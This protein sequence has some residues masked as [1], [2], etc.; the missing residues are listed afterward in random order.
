MIYNGSDIKMVHFEPT[1]KCQ[2]SCPMC[3]RNKNGGEVNQYLTNRDISIE[4]FKKIFSIDFL[5]QL[6][7]FFFC[8]NHG[9]P[10]LCPDLIPMVKYVREHNP[11]IRMWITT[12][13]GARTAK[14]W[15]E[16]AQYIS[17]VNF[18]VD[19]LEDTNHLYRQGVVWDKVD[20]AM[21]AFCGA[22]GKAE[23]TFL[24]FEYNEHQVEHARAYAEMLGVHK[25]IVKKSGRYITTADLE[26]K[27]THT[28][29]DKKGNRNILGKPK[30]PKYH[31]KATEVDY[32]RIVKEYGSLNNYIESAQI[33]PKC[34]QKKEIY[35]SA[36]GLVFQCCWLGGQIYKWWRPK[37][38]GDIYQLIEKTGGIDKIN[39]LHYPIEEILQS[40]FYNKVEESWNLKTYADG[41]LKTCALK[42]NKGFDPFKA[43]WQ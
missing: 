20:T 7:S 1:Q 38:D 2:A 6:E 32:G 3:D 13:G 28:H 26:K 19:G 34:Q 5:K 9:D 22:G 43:Q 41:R 18:S 16:L 39:A 12:N 25:F 33:V 24:V 30:N 23:W 4:E 10:I 29:T 14:W 42:C 21:D 37:E 31:N 15:E 40:E 8:G 27:E 35:V 36:E 17:F 11:N